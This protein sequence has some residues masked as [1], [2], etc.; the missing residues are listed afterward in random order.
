MPDV[1]KVITTKDYIIDD[2]LIFK[3]DSLYVTGDMNDEGFKKCFN[4]HSSGGILGC[5]AGTWQEYGGGL[6]MEASSP[7]EAKDGRRLDDAKKAEV[8]SLHQKGM[9][10]T[11]IHREAG[12]SRPTIYKWIKEKE[13]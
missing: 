2:T 13:E 11:G 1:T 7:E 8:L 6:F 3:G 9:S 5:L 4:V 12:V 10:V